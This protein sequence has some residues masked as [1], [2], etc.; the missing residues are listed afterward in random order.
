MEEPIDEKI[1]D[2]SLGML[3]GLTVAPS[4]AAGLV[5]SGA[6]KELV[7]AGI[8]AELLAG[9]ISMGLADYLSID[10]LETRRDNAL[11]SGIRTASGYVLG[12]GLSLFAYYISKDTHDGLRLSIIFNVV[13]LIFLGYIRSIYLKGTNPLKVLFIG[14]IA[15]SVTYF[16]FSK[17]KRVN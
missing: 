7:I 6:S 4:V 12:A 1:S 9:S 15:M 2:W 3:D 13:A 5:L 10:T 8:F 11:N 17:F 16:I 14:F